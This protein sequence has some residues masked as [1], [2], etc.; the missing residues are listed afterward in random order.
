M[1]S[2][3]ELKNHINEKVILYYYHGETVCEIIETLKEVDDYYSVTID[4]VSYPFISKVAGIIA[5][6]AFFAPAIFTL[7]SR[8]LLFFITIFLTFIKVHLLVSI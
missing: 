8:L 6:A 4:N 5:K 2:F 1:V 3:D 7:P